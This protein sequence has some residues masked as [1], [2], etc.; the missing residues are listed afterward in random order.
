MVGSFVWSGEGGGGW[1]R[2]GDH[3]S[4]MPKALA[5]GNGEASR[6]QITPH[7]AGRRIACQCRQNPNW[8]QRVPA[9]DPQTTGPDWF[10]IKPIKI[11][12]IYLQWH[13]A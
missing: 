2:S 4:F 5:L 12:G 10:W 3:I 7:P 6:L 11:P 9:S 13:G 1:F 8:S